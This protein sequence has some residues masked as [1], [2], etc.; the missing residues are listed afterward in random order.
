MPDSLTC[1]FEAVDGQTPFSQGVAIKGGVSRRSLA[2]SR[3]PAFSR[4]LRH[5]SGMEPLRR[6]RCSVLSIQWS[7]LGENGILF[8]Q[9]T[10]PLA[11]VI[12]Y[13]PSV[14]ASDRFTIIPNFLESSLAS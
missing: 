9:Y 3:C 10:F 5:P 11:A 14:T 1:A 12:R 8:K 7:W 2:Y 13:T 6:I 4:V